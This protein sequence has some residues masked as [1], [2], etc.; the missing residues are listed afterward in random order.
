EVEVGRRGAET[1]RRLAGAEG[2]RG[3]L[4]L[5]VGLHGALQRGAF[6]GPGDPRAEEVDGEDE[7][8]DGGDLPVAGVGRAGGGLL[9]EG[10][11]VGGR[12]ARHEGDRGRRGHR[13]GGEPGGSFHGVFLLGRAFCFRARHGRA[14]PPFRAVS[15]SH[16]RAE[17]IL[18]I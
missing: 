1:V 2:R 15:G 6:A 11:G 13:G 8:A 3:Q 4:A 5:A 10:R 7:R 9:T 18:F 16:D 17:Y 14:R 12:G